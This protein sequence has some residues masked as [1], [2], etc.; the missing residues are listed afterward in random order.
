[1]IIVTGANGFIGS[2]IVWEL[3]QA[4]FEDI[5]AVDSVNLQTRNLLQKRK[6]TNFYEASELWS[7][8]ATPE[9]KKSV[10]WIIHMGACSSTTETNWDFLYANN[11][12]YTQRLF[13]WCSQNQKSLIYASSAA[14]YGAGENGFDDTYDS[15]KLKPLN[16]YGDS[17]VIM[18]RWA[19]KQKAQPV[20]WYGLK[21]FNVFGPNEYEKESMASV[22]FKSYNQ[23]KT[24]DQ[25]GLFKSYNSLYKDGEQLRDF[26][27]V[28][29][30]T[31]WIK[32]IM[33][34]KPENGIYNMG[35]GEARSWLDMAKSLFAALK[36]PLKINWLEMPEPI[37]SQYQYFTKANM[38]KWQSQKMSAPEWPLEKAIEDYVVNYL[39][40]QDP[41]L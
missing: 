37:K 32:E 17:K 20:N 3:N 33:D 34:K 19:V 40:K 23:L 4:G 16:L 14:T 31:R 2:A 39:S 41:W 22:A 10:S 30:V 7:F 1:M 21:F 38:T 24:A 18:D 29:D 8:L 9:A 28:K 11:F 26:V 12:Q 5:I 25:L 35:Y 15:E 13:E 6:Y 27:Y 36:K